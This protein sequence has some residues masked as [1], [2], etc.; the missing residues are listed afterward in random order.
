M[1]IK[2][3]IIHAANVE[4]NPEANVRCGYC[5]DSRAPTTEAVGCDY[6]EWT[7]HELEREWRFD[8]PS[9]TKQYHCIFAF[10]GAQ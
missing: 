5:K 4:L 9:N 1:N 2:R 8:H 6:N 7:V 10:Y 3:E